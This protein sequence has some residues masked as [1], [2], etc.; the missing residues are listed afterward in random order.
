MKE[1]IK[2]N[3]LFK[4]SYDVR[5]CL[6][7]ALSTAAI[8]MVV[9]FCY[10]LAP[11]GDVTILR[12]DLYHQYGPLFAEFYERV[13]DLDSFLYSWNSGGGSSFLGNFYNYLSRSRLPQHREGKDRRLPDRQAL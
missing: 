3:P 4:K 11:F 9:Y 12:M 5:F 2:N 8:M 7:A 10:D 13:T 1:R 6:I